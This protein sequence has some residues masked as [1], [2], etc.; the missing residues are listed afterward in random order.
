[1]SDE[2]GELSLEQ[3]EKLLRDRIASIDAQ[4]RTAREKRAAL[5]TEIKRLE[6]EK[7]Q[8]YRMLPRS[9]RRAKPKVAQ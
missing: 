6:V 7:V 9:P 1:M 3:V 4:Q 5:M 8:A 2:N